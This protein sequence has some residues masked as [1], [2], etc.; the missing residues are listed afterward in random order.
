MS[1]F[2]GSVSPSS[3]SK[4][5]SPFMSSEPRRG[6]SITPSSSQS[7]S[8]GQGSRSLTIPSRSASLNGVTRSM[9]Y[10][11]ASPMGLCKGLAS[12]LN[13]MPTS[14]TVAP[15]GTSKYTVKLFQL[16]HSSGRGLTRP[17]SSKSESWVPSARSTAR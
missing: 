14:R 12:I 9:K 8:N 13:T 17:P 7:G 4:K 15:G 10:S 5:P 3:G 2:V 16:S 1:G 11:K 6:P